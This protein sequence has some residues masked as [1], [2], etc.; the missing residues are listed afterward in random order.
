MLS[1]RRESWSRSTIVVIFGPYA[2]CIFPVCRL[3]NSC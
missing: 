1:N 2:L 3:V